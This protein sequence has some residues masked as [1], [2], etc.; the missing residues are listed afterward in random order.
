MKFKIVECI[1]GGSEFKITNPKQVYCQPACHST[2]HRD[3]HGYE[4]KNSSGSDESEVVET[5]SSELVNS[6]MLSRLF[7]LITVIERIQ[8]KKS[9]KNP[10]VNLWVKVVL[11]INPEML[12]HRCFTRVLRGFYGYYT[13]VLR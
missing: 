13:Y 8:D 4:L 9:L 1:Q 11:M 2:A 5:S 12:I 7:R 10:R 3:R 6:A